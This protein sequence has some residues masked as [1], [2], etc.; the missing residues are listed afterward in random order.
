[1][2]HN[3]PIVC[4]AVAC[5][6]W[7]AMMVVNLAVGVVNHEVRIRLLEER[8]PV[9]ITEQHTY[10][11]DIKIPTFIYDIE[12]L[13]DITAVHLRGVLIDSTVELTVGIEDLAEETE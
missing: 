9:Q 8:K 5:V 1:M 6:L 4:I 7:V 3:W 11:L 13:S 10:N 2:K 12:S